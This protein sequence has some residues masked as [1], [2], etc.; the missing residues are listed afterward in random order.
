MINN[1]WK[2]NE[3]A[4]GKTKEAAWANKYE[5]GRS[6][7]VNRGAYTTFRSEEQAK[8]ISRLGQSTRD[9]GERVKKS[10][11]PLNTEE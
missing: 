11:A 8:Q 10:T 3:G 5:A 9:Q 6:Q 2:I 4:Y 1:A 7:N